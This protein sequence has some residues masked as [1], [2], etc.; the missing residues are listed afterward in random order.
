MP[1]YDRYIAVDWSANNGPKTGRDSI[2]IG[3]ATPAGLVASRNPATRTAAMTDVERTLV[4]ARSRGERVMVGFDFVF[5]FP[6]GAAAAIAQVAAPSS[7]LSGT[8]SH[9]GRRESGRDRTTSPS[10]LMGEGGRRPDE[11]GPLA[12][13]SQSGLPPPR[14]E[15]TGEGG[16]FDS[17]P[18]S[19]LWSTLHTL[20]IDTDQNLSNR[21]EVAAHINRATAPRFWGHPH[22]RSYQHLAPTRAGTDYLAIAERRAVETRIRGPQPVW[23]LTGVGSVGS[24]TLLGIP[25]LETLRRHPVLGRDIAI[26]PFD[27]SFERNLLAPIT[28]VE[29]YPSF[30]PLD[31]TAVPRDRAQVETCVLR[32][33]ALDAAG[34]LSPF[35]SAPAD[36]SAEHRATAIAEEG[37]IAGV[38][39]EHLRL[40]LPEAA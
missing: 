40:A 27:T 35:L 39:H 32:Y 14:G 2:W 24:Q 20:I 4:A 1:I 9:E 31:I 30:F 22:G 6:V 7:A 13:A 26:W 38:G 23:K 3:E 29:I 36:L 15:G 28:V 5:G 16:A 33:A 37:W 11:G 25:R 18:W 19:L 21:F 8:F 12:P 10:P 34:L 17:S